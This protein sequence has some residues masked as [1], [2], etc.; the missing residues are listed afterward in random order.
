[1]VHARNLPG[2]DRGPERTPEVAFPRRARARPRSIAACRAPGYGEDQR[3]TRYDAVIFRKPVATRQCSGLRCLSL[4]ILA[5]AAFAAHADD[6]LVFAAASLKPA[7]DAII[8]LPQ[9]AAI[10]GA[11][12]VYAASSQLARQIEHGA[13][14]AVFISADEDWMDEVGNRG[15]LAPG[16]RADLL[17]NALVLI[18]PRDVP[19]EVTIAPG[20]DL[21]AA[22]G[23]D[24]RLA[25]AEPDSVPA[26]KYAK[27]SLLA[28]GAWD[29]VAARVIAADNVRAA[30]NFVVRGAAPLGIVY[31]SDAVSEPAVRVVG[32]F[33]AASH[34]PIVYPAA[35]VQTHDG[36]AARAL[37][38]VLRSDAVRAVFRRYGF[39]AAPPA[40]ARPATG[41]ASR[42]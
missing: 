28:L 17:G 30:L 18:A 22:L 23:A 10:G 31:R 12:P 13:P 40:G 11:K 6:R 21:A 42:K 4:L 16:T 14:A 19:L 29:G 38:A 36:K 5:G 15:L 7:L 27:Q 2:A 32:R 1:M 8:A 39:D 37:L 24:G 3:P 20:F 33:P 26:G 41:D 25:L 35:I 9:V 34:E